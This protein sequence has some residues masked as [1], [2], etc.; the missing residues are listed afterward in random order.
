MQDLLY[1]VHRFPY[2]PNKGDKIRS[3]HLLK[4]L[5]QRYRVHLGCFIDDVMDRQHIPRLMN[6]CASSCFIEQRP[7]LSRLR[8]LSALLSGEAMSLPYYR[9]K[10]LQHWVDLLL[11]SGQ[12]HQALA[13]SGPMAQYLHPLP[14]E[15]IVR[16]IID[17][18]DVDSEKWSQYAAAKYWPLAQLYRRE[19]RHLLA[20]ERQVTQQFDSATFV[21]SAE[22]NLFRQRA[23]RHNEQCQYEHKISF[24]NNG[25]DADYFSP[26]TKHRNPYPDTVSVLVFTGAMDYWPNIEAVLWFASRVLPALRM[27]F[28]ALQF[29]IVGS[30]PT[31]QVTALRQVPGIIVTGAVPDIRPYLA[32]ASMA[33]APL[34]IARGIQNKVLEAMSMEKTVVASPQAVEGISAVPGIEIIVAANENEFIRHLTC[35]LAG[36]SSYAMGQAARRRVLQDYCWGTNLA[37]LDSMMSDQAKQLKSLS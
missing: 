30:K 6:M 11:G 17:F 5:S 3:Y 37:H 13:F 15:V 35:L 14:A 9:S 23:R 1:L 16:R 7:L 4:F 19:A 12:I 27:R 26:K 29:H 34:R 28:P 25:V 18:V 32:H 20:Y 2:P 21:S 24:F 36:K 22:A 8:S 33:V 31:E 10:K